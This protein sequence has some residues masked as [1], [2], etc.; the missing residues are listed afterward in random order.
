MS[1]QRA[2]LTLLVSFA[3]NRTHH[4]AFG[5]SGAARLAVLRVKVTELSEAV[6]YGSE[7]CSFWTSRSCSGVPPAWAAVWSPAGSVVTV[8][9][10]AVQKFSGG[11][12]PNR[13]TS[14]Q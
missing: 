1:T 12:C 4:V 9:P 3:L 14:R 13:L 5:G 10:G 2:R 8:I 11:A 7:I 6:V